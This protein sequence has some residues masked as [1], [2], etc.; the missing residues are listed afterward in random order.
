MSEQSALMFT[1]LLDSMSNRCAAQSRVRSQ[2]MNGLVTQKAC[3][4][5]DLNIYDSGW[6]THQMDQ[7]VTIKRHLQECSPILKQ[8]NQI[9]F[10]IYAGCVWLAPFVVHYR[11][12]LPLRRVQGR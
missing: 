7:R 2:H 11:K 5:P 4:I 3:S 12:L 9:S 8:F 1:H 10:Q 6:T